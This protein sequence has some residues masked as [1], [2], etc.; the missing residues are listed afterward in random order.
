MVSG[1]SWETSDTNDRI[2]AEQCDNNGDVTHGCD[3]YGRIVPG[4][5]C[6]HYYVAIRETPMLA[7]IEI[8]WFRSLCKITGSNLPAWRRLFGDDHSGF[9][10]EGFISHEDALR[11][12]NDQEDD[13]EW[14]DD[15]YVMGDDHPI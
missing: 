10:S 13:D 5:T 4:W 15:E 6:R 3:M 9:T 11:H 7:E 14:G 2:W 12:Y 8:P 1:N